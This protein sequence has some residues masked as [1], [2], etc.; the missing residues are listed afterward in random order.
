MT[1]AELRSLLHRRG[2]ARIADD[3]VRLAAPT[4]RVFLQPV[5][6]ADH[7]IGASKVG[8][9]ADLPAGVAWPE[10]HEPM[11]FI[12]QFD[13]AAV[14]AHDRE[15]ALST[16]GRLSIFYETDSEPL[17]SAGWGLPEETEPA[18][19]PEV[20]ES[21]GWCVLYHEGNPATFIRRDVPPELNERARFPPCAARFAAEVTL[22]DLNGPEIASL[23]PTETER[24]ALIEIDADVNRGDWETGGHHLLGYPYNLGEQTLVQCELA[25]RRI[26]YEWMAADP[27]RKRRIE[28]E[29]ADRWRLL[30]QVDS[31]DD[32]GMDWAGGGLLHVCI[33][34]EALRARDFSRVWIN[35]QFL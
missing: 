34:R 8:G 2:L 3:L 14:A 19:F 4:V 21:L 5:D 29:A 33:G 15:V 23:R 26:P 35:L 30:V 31:S 1:E 17:Y 28:R 12:A 22:P 10:W 24:L 6:E 18:D 25:A 11:A 7:P 32:A 20:D 9:R 13:L 16:R 27:A